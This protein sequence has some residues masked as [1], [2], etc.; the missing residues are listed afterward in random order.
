MNDHAL[1]QKR[2]RFLMAGIGAGMSALAI[3]GTRANPLTSSS[4]LALPTHYA[5]KA[6]A[7]AFW[8]QPRVVHL[9][10]QGTGDQVR[11]CYWRDGQLV[12]SGYREICHLLRDVRANQAIG[13]DLTLLN[14]MFAG[15]SW[16][17]AQG[18]DDPFL[19]TSGYRT[20]TTNSNTEGAAKNSQHTL[21]RAIDG[22]FERLDAAYTGTLLAGFRAGGVG[23]YLNSKRNFIHVDTGRIRF[24]TQK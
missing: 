6:S 11:A 2:R 20:V 21:G 5:D 24:W 17:Y 18:F 7:D 15:Q 9:R 1:L 23:F 12:P 16:L 8:Q 22:R 13:M 19:V 4:G 10:R 14:M 3:G